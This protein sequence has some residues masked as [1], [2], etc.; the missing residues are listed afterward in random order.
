MG[1]NKGIKMKAIIQVNYNSQGIYKTMQQ[2]DL[3][4]GM[5]K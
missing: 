5:K 3:D 2:S 1:E 4:W